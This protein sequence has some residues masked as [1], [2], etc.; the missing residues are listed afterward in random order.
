[1]RHRAIGQIRV[2][3]ALLA[4]ACFAA[5][6]TFPADADDATTAVETRLLDGVKYLASDDL[7]GRGVGSAGLDQ[8]AEFVRGQFQEAG[9]NVHAVDGGA[10]QTFS[11]TIGANLSEPN[12]LVFTDAEGKEIPLKIDKDFRPLSSGGSGSFSGELAFLGYGIEADDKEYNDFADIDVKGKVVIIMRRTPQQGNPHGNFPDGPHGG[13]SRHAALR[14]KASNAFGAG[15]AAVLFVNEPHSGRSDLKS[16][17]KRMAK[18]EGKLVEAAIAF[19]AVDPEEAEALKTAREKLSAAVQTLNARRD[20]VKAGMPDELIKF[21]Y[22][23]NKEQHAIPLLHISREVCDRVLKTA[24]TSLS[25][26][27]SKIDDEFKPQSQTLKGWQASGEVSIQRVQAEVKNVIGVLEGEGPLADETVVIGAHYDHVGRGGEGSLAPGSKEIHN[28]ADDNASGTAALVELARRFAARQEKPPRRLVFIAFTAEELGLLGSAQYVKEPVFPL[29][30]TVAMFNMDMVGRL[31]DDKL[32]IF[33][34]GT[35]PRWEKM[36]DEMG[37]EYGFKV[38]KKPEGFGPSD[39]SSFYGKKIPVL[40]FFTGTHSDYHRPGDDWEKVNPAGMRRVVEVM[41]R[42]I[43]DVASTPE[44]PKYV[45]VKST[46]G[47]P[48]GGSRP[49]FGSIPDFSQETAGYALMGV[50]PGSPADKAGL[51]AG[52]VI[53]EIDQ[54][55][56]GNLN[57][58]DLALR[59]FKGG[60]T[61]KVV[62]LRGKEKKTLEVTLDKP[63]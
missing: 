31:K 47:M 10:Y 33:G 60:D 23:G 28:G 30:K 22:E 4:L 44:R 61:I 52:D 13:V 55:K 19:D 54:K 2:L 42:M 58:F 62:V 16:A 15:A 32:T 25:E 21:G 34:S 3:G 36:I 51:K 24:G 43:Q 48:R 56:I 6:A 49:Y 41:E 27:E 39:H 37:K 14:T 53:V 5:V 18:A 26:L 12:R 11:M 29:D 40:H 8:A 63:R 17:E 9:L 59:K 35:A 57:D 7:E 20:D 38:T 1:M 45:A 50:S 46:A